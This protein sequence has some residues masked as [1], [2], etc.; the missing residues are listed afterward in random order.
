[1]N[2]II[3][4]TRS[5]G[6][7]LDREPF[8]IVE[9]DGLTINI[10]G[11]PKNLKLTATVRNGDV[12]A[13]LK[14]NARTVEIPRN[15]LTAGRLDVEISGFIDGNSVKQWHCEPIYLKTVDT[16]FEGHAEFERILA[17]Q[18]EIINAL[19][20][21]QNKVNA[22]QAATNQAIETLASIIDNG[23]VL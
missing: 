11:A 18:A 14:E 6:R 1:M 12:S 9:N 20:S 16:G 13:T 15:L 22:N 2:K 8:L 19:N 3:K 10:E 4:L 7:L 21:L 5:L 23:R 17:R